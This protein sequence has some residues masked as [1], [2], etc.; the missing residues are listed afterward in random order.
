MSSYKI[1]ETHAHYDDVALMR[2]GM[3]FLV[4][5]MKMEFRKLLMCVRP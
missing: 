1:F 5:W 3:Y 4:L 2:T